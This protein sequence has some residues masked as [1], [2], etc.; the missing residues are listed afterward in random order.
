M[1]NTEASIVALFLT[2]GVQVTARLL[3]PASGNEGSIKTLS[4]FMCLFAIVVS[5]WF[6]FT[7]ALSFQPFFI[8]A[9]VAA[10]NGLAIKVDPIV[11]KKSDPLGIRDKK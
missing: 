7:K 2:V 9:V 3:A 11:R 10:I 5:G 4:I 8:I 1:T 6:Y